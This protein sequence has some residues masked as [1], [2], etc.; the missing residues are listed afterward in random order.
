M[1]KPIRKSFDYGVLPTQRE[2][3]MLEV[4]ICGLTWVHIFSIASCIQQNRTRESVMFDS[5]EQT[6][7]RVLKTTE[8]TGL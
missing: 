3:T 8:R 2:L 4:P 1:M 7:Q 5:K 6:H